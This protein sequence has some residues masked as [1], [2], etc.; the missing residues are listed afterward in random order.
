MAIEARERWIAGGGESVSVDG[1]GEREGVRLG[2]C[3]WAGAAVEGR[4][5]GGGWNWSPSLHVRQRRLA[6]LS[7][8]IAGRRRRK[9]ARGKKG[10]ETT[11]VQVADRRG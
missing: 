11:G 3:R 8:T 4:G 7:S 9:G 2:F 10:R 6:M 1:K 5:V